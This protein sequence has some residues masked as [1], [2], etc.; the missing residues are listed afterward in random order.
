MAKSLYVCKRAILQIYKE[1]MSKNHMSRTLLKCPKCDKEFIHRS[2]LT[3]HHL[4]HMDEKSFKC[5][6]CDKAYTQKSSLNRHLLT[7]LYEKLF[8]CTKCGKTFSS[9]NNLQTHIKKN[10]C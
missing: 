5:E 4:S 10:R 6:S 7:H 1:H 2:K 9:K 3:Q 8:R